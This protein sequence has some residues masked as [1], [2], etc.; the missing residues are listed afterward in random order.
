MA[1][2][3]FDA[4]LEKQFLWLLFIPLDGILIGGDFRLPPSSL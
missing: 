3:K 1:V 2:G 4:R